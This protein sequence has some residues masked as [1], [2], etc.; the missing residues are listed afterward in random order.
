MTSDSL[1]LISSPY[2]EVFSYSILS[3]SIL[4]EK[5]ITSKN[6]IVKFIHPN[7]KEYKFII[8]LVR[9]ELE[10]ALQNNH[11]EILVAYICFFSYETNEHETN[12]PFS[13]ESF[14][15][16]NS[17]IDVSNHLNTDMKLK[18]ILFNFMSDINFNV[19][20]HFIFNINGL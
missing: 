8:Y 11:G 5:T 20:T 12:E 13:I 15:N 17:I 18:Q 9:H 2:K 19:L 16:I 6:F 7:Y 1:N 4:S 10:I 3:N 14:H